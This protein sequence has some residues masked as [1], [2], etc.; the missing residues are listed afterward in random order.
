MPKPDAN[1][2]MCNPGD[3]AACIDGLMIAAGQQRAEIERLRA[4]LAFYADRAHYQRQDR[5]LCT[6]LYDCGAQARD[7]IEQTAATVGQTAEEK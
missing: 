3:A 1:W 2:C 6:I 4:A 7:A 5:G